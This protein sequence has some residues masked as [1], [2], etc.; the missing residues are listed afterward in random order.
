[1]AAVCGMFGRPAPRGAF[2]PRRGA[3]G[4]GN[5]LYGDRGERIQTATRHNHPPRPC[6]S[7]A[8]RGGGSGG[9]SNGDD[10]SHG[11]GGGGGDA[12]AG[13]RVQALL[14]WEV[15][16][17]VVG[18]LASL[19]GIFA[20]WASLQQ[21]LRSEKERRASKATAQGALKQSV[22]NM[23][24]A[25]QALDIKTSAAVENLGHRVDGVSKSLG[26][27]QDVL[28]AGLVVTLTKLFLI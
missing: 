23:S 2:G 24:A 21:H 16:L 12:R 20:G 22:D 25:L 19:A 27:K 7:Y 6:S 28:L 13:T 18:L 26:W 1:M 4:L 15:L 3:V 11:G 10:A 14:R 9:G 8:E 5:A 17:G